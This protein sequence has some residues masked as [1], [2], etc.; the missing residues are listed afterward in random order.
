MY[1]HNMNSNNQA[2]MLVVSVPF[3]CTCGNEDVFLIP[4]TCSVD[5]IE[6]SQSQHVCTDCEFSDYEPAVYY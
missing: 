3:T 1:I 4:I 6:L 5:S 2:S